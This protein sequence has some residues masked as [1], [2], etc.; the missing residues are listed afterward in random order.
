MWESTGHHWWCVHICMS[1]CIGVCDTLPLLT[2]RLGGQDWLEEFS[3]DAQ[4][5]LLYS[6]PFGQRVGEKLAV[7]HSGFA[8]TIG[9]LLP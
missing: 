9:K 3:G 1:V 8:L 4:T 2:H 7:N 5:F 6:L